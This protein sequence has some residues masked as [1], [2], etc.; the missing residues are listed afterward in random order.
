MSWVSRARYSICIFAMLGGR[1]PAVTEGRAKSERLE[2][3]A[4]SMTCKDSYI[5]WDTGTSSSAQRYTSSAQQQE[6][7]KSTPGWMAGQLHFR[8]VGGRVVSVRWRQ[9]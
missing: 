4:E 2:R 3:N 9:A 5:T 8:Q 7:M 1:C 6:P